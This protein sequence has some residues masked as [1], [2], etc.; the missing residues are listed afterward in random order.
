MI[1]VLRALEILAEI[2]VPRINYIASSEISYDIKHVTASRGA[3]KLFIELFTHPE[4]VKMC[5]MTR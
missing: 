2:C 5:A 1:S 4:N 3:P